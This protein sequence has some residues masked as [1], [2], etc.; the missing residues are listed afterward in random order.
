VSPLARLSTGAAAVVMGSLSLLHL[1][2]AAGSSW[3]MGDRRSLTDAVV[4]RPD[5]VFPPPAAC[6]LVAGALAAGAA[7][8]LPTETPA[9]EMRLAGARCCTAA[10]ALRGA[11]GMC[12][13]TD[14][15][16]PGSTSPRFRALDRR[17]YSPLCLALAVLSCPA[18]R[19]HGSV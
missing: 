1:G 7:S 8:V 2:W 3:P 9:A 16:S 13:R 10:F 5:G 18:A 4:G 19:R 11:A 12:G 14:L 15:F 6:T 17:I